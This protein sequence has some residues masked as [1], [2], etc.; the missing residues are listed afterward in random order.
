MGQMAQ[1]NAQAKAAEYKAKQDRMLAEDSIKRGAQAEES[2]RQRTKALIG[3][4]KAVQAAGNLDLSSGSPLTVMADT[5]MLG[6]FDAQKIRDNAQREK[7]H[8]NTQA[9]LGFMEADNARSAGAWGAFSTILGG[10][11]SVAQKWYG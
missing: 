3:R 9:E 5:A 11:G 8:H 2:H 10:V 7:Q 1:A 4:Q 6:E